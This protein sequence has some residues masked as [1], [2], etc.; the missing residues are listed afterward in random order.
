MKPLLKRSLISWEE[1]AEC[2]IT[3]RQDS[4]WAGLPC[5]KGNSSMEEEKS[6]LISWEG[7]TCRSH[8]KR[9]DLSQ[10]QHLVHEC[11]KMKGKT[12]QAQGGL[13]KDVRVGQNV[14]AVRQVP[15]WR[16]TKWTGKRWDYYISHLST[17]PILHPPR[18]YTLPPTLALLFPG[19]DN[20]TENIPALP[21]MAQ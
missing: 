18:T 10:T 15:S 21:Q 9:R 20:S 2:K 12:K 6:R 5:F 17:R 16:V 1:I 14:P 7:R 11:D 8:W 4:L 19:R 3:Q 13:R